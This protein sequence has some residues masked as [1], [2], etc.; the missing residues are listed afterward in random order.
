MKKES[1]YEGELFD[2]FATWLKGKPS[3]EEEDV[4]LLS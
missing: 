2:G 4:S 1:N 3:E